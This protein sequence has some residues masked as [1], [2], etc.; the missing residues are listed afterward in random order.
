MIR[1][2][3]QNSAFL[4]ILFDE[5]KEGVKGH[6]LLLTEE[7]EFSEVIINVVHLPRAIFAKKPLQDAPSGFDFLSIRP[8]QWVYEV[9]AVVN[10][11]VFE[12]LD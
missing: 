10:L 7:Y 12:M 9:L 2:L 6:A 4:K 1:I 11:I 3:K 5:R 8:I